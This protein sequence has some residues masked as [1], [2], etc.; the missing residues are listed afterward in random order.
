[1]KTLEQL[2]IE[3]TKI[4]ESMARSNR[5]GEARRFAGRMAGNRVEKLRHVESQIERVLEKEVK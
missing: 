5:W 1:M 3:R 4:Y 2:L